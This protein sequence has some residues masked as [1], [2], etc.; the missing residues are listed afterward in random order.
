MKKKLF[1]YSSVFISLAILFS[2]PIISNLQDIKEI[3][4][5]TE[6]INKDIL[7]IEDKISDLNME[8]EQTDDLDYIE[9]IVR[10]R[11]GYIK[12]DEIVFI[13]VEK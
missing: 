12:A 2:I 3:E 7:A 9:K 5:E 6:R 10:E 13:A 11:Y 4:A 8:M 1:I